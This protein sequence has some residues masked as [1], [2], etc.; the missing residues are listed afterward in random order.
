MN[1]DLHM[2]LFFYTN[3]SQMT[4]LHA[5]SLFY[6]WMRPSRTGHGERDI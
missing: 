3:P 1:V 2:Y 6:T 5:I 4:R